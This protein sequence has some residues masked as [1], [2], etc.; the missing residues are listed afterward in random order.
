MTKEKV[1]TQWEVGKKTKDNNAIIFTVVIFLIAIIA[2]IYY[3]Y[4]KDY[5]T[6][7]VFV[8]LSLVLIWYFFASPK[9]A[10]VA[11]LEKGVKV[12]N[13]F[14]KFENFKSYWVSDKTGVF[15][16]EPKKRI[17]SIASFPSGGKS[18]DEI[19]KYLPEDLIETEDKGDDFTN[20]IA[21][22]L[23]I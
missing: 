23:K 7:A 12:N 6:G 19:K 3:F 1:L 11:I 9:S 8:V 10:S 2:A 13:Q 21:D 17:G 20:K 4:Q 15:Y 22:L 18:P 14:Y 5:Y 16:L